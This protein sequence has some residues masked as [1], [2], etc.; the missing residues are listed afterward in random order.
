MSEEE[1][2]NMLNGLLEQEVKLAQLKKDY[3]LLIKTVLPIQK[4]L[5][6]HRVEQEFMNHMLNQIRDNRNPGDSKSGRREEFKNSR[7]HFPE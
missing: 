7:D 1:L 5:K 6:L 3:F 2:S 4:V